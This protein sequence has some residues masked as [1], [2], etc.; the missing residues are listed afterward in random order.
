MT[1]S[2]DFSGGTVDEVLLDAG[3]SEVHELR[4]LLC[5]LASLA[6][7][8]AP[9]P[10][11]E[12][13][14]MLAG[15][16]DELTRQRWLRKHRPAV[17]GLAVLAGMGL[18]VSGVAA[19]SSVPG[20]GS[21]LR[22]VQLLT[23]DWIPAWTIPLPSRPT[24][25]QRP[26]GWASPIFLQTTHEATTAADSAGQAGRQGAGT[27]GSRTRGADPSRVPRGNGP[28]SK[29]SAVAPGSAKGP[30]PGHPAGISGPGNSGKVSGGSGKDSSGKSSPSNGS[31]PA[32]ATGHAK[33]PISAGGPGG[34]E[35][36]GLALKLPLPDE[37]TGSGRPDAGEPTGSG[38]DAA[39]GSAGSW[40]K[41]FSR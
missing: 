11:P 35:T 36:G 8:P 16:C 1:T 14:A 7:L 30:G 6:Q 34:A 17:I 31:A 18:G 39:T 26:A 12:L 10:G 41:R 2:N 33:A 29:T 20:T 21:G 25:A 19:T 4:A 40:L 27:D 9:A 24:A 32:P 5:S 3:H 15:P 28:E 22:S 13:A 23:S 38:R 37:A